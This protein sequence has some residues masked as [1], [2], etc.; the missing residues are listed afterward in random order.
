MAELENST[1]AKTSSETSAETAAETTAKTAAETA[2][3]TA[4]K[5]AAKT[6]S[7]TAAETAV[8][9]A[10]ETAAKTSA[11]PVEKGFFA[12][13]SDYVFGE[14]APVLKPAFLYRYD[15]SQEFSGKLREHAS[16]QYH[17]AAEKLNHLRQNASSGARSTYTIA[18]GVENVILGT[19]EELEWAETKMAGPAKTVFAKSR[20]TKKKAKCP[21][22]SRNPDWD[23]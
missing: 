3:E 6:S 13:V 5:T 16:E 23:E 11:E 1:D 21:S 22:S 18:G 19:P 9:T 2:A 7:E 8:E 12:N 4:A 10:A 15:G 17:S 20:G 14:A